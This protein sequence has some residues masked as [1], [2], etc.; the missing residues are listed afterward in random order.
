[1]AKTLGSSKILRVLVAEGDGQPLAAMLLI[2]YGDTATYSHGA[3]SDNA[4]NLMAPHLLQWKAIEEAKADGFK[5]YDFR[6]IAL[7]DDPTHPWAGITRFK[8]GF[9]GRVVRYAGTYDLPLRKSLYFSYRLAQ[10][11]FRRFR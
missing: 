3:S 1:M 6:G 9:G 7:S 11:V 8:A 10:S 5:L 2:R 4:R